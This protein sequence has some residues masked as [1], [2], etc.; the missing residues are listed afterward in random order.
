[1]SRST[2]RRTTQSRALRES[3]E[4]LDE[5]D[6]LRLVRGDHFGKITQMLSATKWAISPM[7]GSD[8]LVPVG[9]GCRCRAR[10]NIQ[11]AEK[12]AD[13]AIYRPPAHE[14]LRRNHLVR[15]AGGD[16]SKDLQLKLATTTATPGWRDIVTNASTGRSSSSGAA[17]K[18]PIASQTSEMTKIA[19][20]VHC[21]TTD[22][23]SDHA[24]AMTIGGDHLYLRY[25]TW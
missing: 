5:R 19:V 24:P 8:E 11:L 7:W 2:A 20:V 14:K 23:I 13:V 1:M 9:V 15:L 3:I 10:R 12:I 6:M 17:K 22:A 21:G 4:L 18:S 25:W 16:Q